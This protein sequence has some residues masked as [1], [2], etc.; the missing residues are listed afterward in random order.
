M[1]DYFCAET[2]KE[3]SD[4]LF[5]PAEELPLPTL[6]PYF[7]DK[8]VVFTYSQYEIAPYS[9]GCPECTISYEDIRPLLS[10]FALSLID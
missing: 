7:T 5:S 1:A 10:Q 2:I 9:E 3:L 4:H 8:G 6:T